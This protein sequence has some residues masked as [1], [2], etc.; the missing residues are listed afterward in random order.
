MEVSYDRCPRCGAEF[1]TARCDKCTRVDTTRPPPPAQA[2]LPPPPLPPTRDRYV[3]WAVRAVMLLVSATLLGTCYS[4]CGE[5]P[6]FMALRTDKDGPSLSRARVLLVFLHGYGGSISDVTWVRD[7][8][9]KAGPG[10]D[11]A[12]WLVDGPY[13]SGFGRSWGDS[14]NQE[15]ASIERVRSLL[16]EAL[17]GG[18]LPPAR[19]VIAGFSQGAGLAGDV[20]AVESKVGGLAAFSACRFRSRDSLAAR[21]DMHFVV[22]HGKSDGLCP[23]GQSRNLVE[24]IRQAGSEVTFIEFDDSHVIPKEAIL[25]LAELLRNTK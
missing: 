1:R 22:A 24:A 10:D 11:V 16:A 2:T 6:A 14:A 9:R 21:K 5:R 4:R 19:V 8:L 23:I 20:A 15:A 17:A 12:I 7:E 13:A 3:A 18:T 25:A